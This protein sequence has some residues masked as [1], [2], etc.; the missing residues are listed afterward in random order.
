MSSFSS[1]QIILSLGLFFAFIYAIARPSRAQIESSGLLGTSINGGSETQSCNLGV[2]AIS[3]GTNA[4]SNKFHRFT[5]FD[6]NS[7][8][9]GVTI[10]TDSQSNIILGIASSSNGFNL[11]VP[12]S[13][14][15]SANLFI[16]SPDGISLS[17]GASFS[18]VVD[19]TLTN[20]ST[21]PLASGQFSVNSSASE[22][23]LLSAPPALSLSTSSLSTTA[24]GSPITIGAV[25]LSVDGSLYVH[26]HSD[27]TLSNTTL[28]S[29]S[30]LD[31]GGNLTVS[32]STLDNNLS[33]SLYTEGNLDI[34]NSTIDGNSVVDLDSGN[35]LTIS[36]STSPFDA[37]VSISDNTTVTI[38]SASDFKAVNSDF[39]SNDSLAISVGGS[40]FADT[41]PSLPSSGVY[42]DQNMMLSLTT[43]GDINIKNSSVSGNS[44]VAINSGGNF[45]FFG[46]D[47]IGNLPYT[48]SQFQ[49]SFD[50]VDTLPYFTIQAAGLIDIADSIIDLNGPFELISTMSDLSIKN[51][52]FFDNLYPYIE[53]IEGNITFENLELN[54]NAFFDAIA[55]VDASLFNSS[56]FGNDLVFLAK[57]GDAVID[58]SSIVGNALLI[59]APQGDAVIVSSNL[60]SNFVTVRSTDGNAVIVDSNS[61]NNF[62]DVVSESGDA[63]IIDSDVI[64]TDVV[65]VS[66]DGDSVIVDSSVVNT[67]A[68]VG[69]ETGD[70]AIAGSEVIGSDVLAISSEGDVV[71]F[72]SNVDE[73]IFEAAALT[74]NIDVL[75]S[76]FANNQELAFVADF[77]VSISDSSVS[78][79]ELVLIDVG[80]DALIDSTTMTDNEGLVMDSAYDLAITSTIESDSGSVDVSAGG[81]IQDSGSHSQDAASSGPYSSSR[82]PSL[83]ASSS[84]S[85]GESA[86]TTASNSESAAAVSS[87]SESESN[88]ESA[89]DEGGNDSSSSTASN[90][91]ASDS[92]SGDSRSSEPGESS[93]PSFQI[94]TVDANVVTS[95]LRD[96]IAFNTAE[97]LSALGLDDISPTPASELTPARISQSLNDARQAYQ[98]LSFSSLDQ[99][100]SSIASD[101]SSNMTLI[102]SNVSDE[103]FNPAF[104]NITFTQNSDLGVGDSSKGFIDLTLITS[105]GTV[106]GRRTEL[107]LAELSNLL[108]GFYGK[109]TSQR[110]LDPALQTSEASRLYSVFLEP[111]QDV[112]ITEKITTVLV[113]ADRGLQAIPFSAL[114][115]QGQYAVENLSFS[116]TPSLSLTDLSIPLANSELERILIMGSTQFSELSPLP[117]VNQEVEN[118]G[119]YYGGQSVLGEQFTSSRAVLDLRSSNESLIHLATHADFKGGSPDQS[120]IYTS[121]G[122]IS[123]ESFKSI[124][125]NRELNPINLFV[126]SACRSALG[127]SES[128]MG[129]AGLA[130]QAG[131]KSAIGSLWYVDD[132]ATSAFFSQFYRYLSRGVSK[133]TALTRT[134][135]DFASGKIKIEGADVVFGAGNVLLSGLSA[136]QKYNYPSDFRHPFFWSGFVLLGTPW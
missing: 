109:I 66:T 4:G 62:L 79:N 123:F 22:V 104:L 136:S 81:S 47:L 38:D 130:L 71:V 101:L 125:R 90:K 61:D 134:Q 11:S 36:D 127:D 93:A 27:L 112:M 8:I 118:I 99:D 32:G 21:L 85:G 96:S 88:A 43:V 34:Y 30:T 13:L 59:N 102:T 74:G 9:S 129:L 115:R 28:N 41:A 83:N 82:Q 56:V 7:P 103:E 55:S 105:D 54:N 77:D 72:G 119:R 68:D 33:L 48:V 111:L 97:V 23:Q 89:T 29:S 39:N 52:D 128:E 17:T 75:G 106:T 20:L 108:R 15:S 10:E 44:L 124:R 51:S 117:Y 49:S 26:A 122:S 53:S 95:N 6:A 18:N 1:K 121:D 35:I 37:G 113:S 98:S 73:S 107:P 70:A 16:V 58:S 2:C 46:S 3:G 65:V 50:V 80:N 60:S 14:D 132:L 114:A 133:S 116:F 24:S 57:Q 63:V 78:G 45:V 135:R 126:L 92:K 67:V 84:D 12:L 110:P 87:D 42:F 86:S 31:A 69:S 76:E 91:D 25:T 64:N 5:L 19:L 131:S 120:M 94:S 40:F 100:T